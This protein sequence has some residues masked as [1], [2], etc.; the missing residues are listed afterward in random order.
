MAY[1]MS[2]TNASGT[3]VIDSE[4]SRLV[5]LHRGDYNG[6][7]NFPSPVTSQE[8]PLVFIRPNSSFVLSYARINGSAGNWTGFSFSGGGSGKYFA[9]AFGATPTARFGFRLWNGAGKLLVDSGTPCAQFT[10]TISAWTN[11]GSGSTGQGTTQVNF[12]APSPL[13]TGDF[14]LINNIGMDV[15]AGQAR[16]AKLYCSWDYSANRIVMFTVG[17][18]NS[19]TFYVP[20]VFAKPIT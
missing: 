19:A 15:S 11:I 14:M 10:R 12:T 2:F 4:F 7:I 8:P 9:A 3:V 18:S 13:N 1:G 20:V 17:V 5:V 6:P 16:S